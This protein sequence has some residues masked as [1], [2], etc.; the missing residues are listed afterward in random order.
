M[1]RGTR[2]SAATRVLGI[3]GDPIGHSLSPLMQNEALV[4]AGIDAV[5]VPFRVEA[6]ELP[7]AVDAVRALGL[8]GVNVTIP[9]KEA[10]LPLLDE[11][12]PDARLIG[13]VNTVVNRAGRLIGFNTDA[14]GFLGAL[15]EDLDFVPTGRRILL[16]GAGGAARAAL[17]ALCRAGA[18]FVAVANRTP[19]RAEALVGE[20][21]GGFPG[22][23]FAHC[24]MDPEN[25]TSQAPSVDLVVNATSLGLK[26]EVPADFP[27]GAL[28][29]GASFYDMVYSSSGTPMVRAVREHGLRS[30][31]GLG[32]LAGQG[33]AAFALWFGRPAPPGVMHRRLLAECAGK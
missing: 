32:M 15:A 19:A 28:P 24:G 18:A 23:K 11:V 25:L 21:G 2:V 22:T 5:Y 17:V 33:E 14:T 7:A 16:L 4:Q 10:V 27:W 29:A 13:A 31:S 26:G 8:V 12:D 1:I 20:L 6:K 9:H 3:F 30:A